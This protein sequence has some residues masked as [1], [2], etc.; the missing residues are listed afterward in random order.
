LEQVSGLPALETDEVYVTAFR[1]G[2]L[3][4]PSPIIVSA[5]ALCE[6]ASA[7][8]LTRYTIETCCE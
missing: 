4:R 8:L 5:A 6:G 1:S 7:D 3:H 2:W